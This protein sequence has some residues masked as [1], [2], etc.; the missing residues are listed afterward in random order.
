[1]VI[2]NNFTFNTIFLLIIRSNLTLTHKNIAIHQI[3]NN[4]NCQNFDLT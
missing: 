2:E 4:F 1:M 3:L